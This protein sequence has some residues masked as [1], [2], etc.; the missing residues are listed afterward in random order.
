MR[1]ADQATN[2]QRL[3]L[4][5]QAIIHEFALSSYECTLI[6]GLNSDG[7]P[8]EVFIKMAKAGSTVRG[9]MDTIGVLF[10]MALQHGAPLDTIVSK[11]SKVAF[12][13][14]GV[15]SPSSSKA[16]SVVDYIAGWLDAS[17]CG[18]AMK[19][20]NGFPSPSESTENRMATSPS[21]PTECSPIHRT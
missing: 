3:P 1:V 11:L 4:E 17:F 15:A 10:S 21:P 6:V 18:F 14:S 16:T 19:T 13:P 5:R 12:E 7:Q 8:L 9:L 20:S 2:R